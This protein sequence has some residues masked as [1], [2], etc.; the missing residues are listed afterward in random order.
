M[1]DDGALT[2]PVRRLGAGPPCLLLH[3]FTGSGAAWPEPCLKGIARHTSLLVPDLPGHG[4]APRPGTAEA[5]GLPAVLDALIAVLD[6]AGVGRA[7]WIGYSL[8]GRIALAA[9]RLRP[10]RVAGVVLESAS[11]GLATEEERADRRHHDDLLA[12]RIL[13]GG[14]ADFVDGWM[15]QPLFATQRRLDEATLA[16]ERSRRLLN[17]GAALAAC[18]RGLG[19]GSQ[20][21]FWHRL[22]EMAVPALVLTGALDRKFT[23]IGARMAEAIPGALHDVVPEAGH[24]VHLERPMEWVGRVSRFLERLAW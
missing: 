14:I 1:S 23:E 15:S 6:R 20:P 3:G 24:A 2:L 16:A 19:A 22:E 21:S 18:L 17:D 4:G 12:R 9:S 8:G 11:P 5:Y 13:E 7:V 10:H